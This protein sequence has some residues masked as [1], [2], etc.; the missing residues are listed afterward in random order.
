[1]YRQLVRSL[2]YVT[3]TRPDITFVASLLARFMHGPSKKH[4]GVTNRVLRYIQ[5]T[6]DYGIEYEK[7]K[8]SILIGYCDSDWSGDEIEHIWICF[9]FLLEVGF[10]LGPQLNNILLLCQQLKLST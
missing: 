7:G 9:F 6:L 8:E 5:G 1:M 2:L 4:M 3:A 10:S